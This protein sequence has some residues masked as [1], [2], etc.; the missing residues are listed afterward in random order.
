[1]EI[2]KDQPIDEDNKE[3]SAE[4]EDDSKDEED[5]KSDE[6]QSLMYLKDSEKDEARQLFDEVD[7]NCDDLIDFQDLIKLLE[8]MLLSRTWL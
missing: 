8:S 3:D 6:D 5:K 4:K 2:A 1:M 7:E